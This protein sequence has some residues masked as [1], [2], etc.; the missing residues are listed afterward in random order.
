[1]MTK[2]WFL[3]RTQNETHALASREAR[4]VR[5]ELRFV[6][7]APHDPERIYRHVEIR[8]QVLA[9]ALSRLSKFVELE[10]DWD[11]YGAARI[12]PIA[13]S[14]AKDILTELS[15]RN[16][17]ATSCDLAP[18]HISPTASGGVQIEWRSANGD[19]LELGVEP[20]GA[21]SILFDR[22]TSYRRF[23]RKI[24]ITIAGAVHEV[25][26]FAS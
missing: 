26:T 2:S 7:S 15:F 25:E 24:G 17:P 16:S 5:S 3:S 8:Q 22:P 1:M 18:Y 20:D 4:F 21:V 13:I 12:S 14:K 10:P 23:S 6:S 9:P 11:S 19:A